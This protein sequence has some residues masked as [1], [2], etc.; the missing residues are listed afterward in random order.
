LTVNPQQRMHQTGH[1]I[2]T[3]YNSRFTVKEGRDAN[4]LDA[5]HNW[6][7]TNNNECVSKDAE[8]MISFQC[9]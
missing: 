5:T 8:G 3:K 7:I 2:N 4:N 9:S 6:S 1:T